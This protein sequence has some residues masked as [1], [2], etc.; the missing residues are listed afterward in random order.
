M[1]KPSGYAVLSTN[2]LASWHN[3]AALVIGWQ[4]LPC[5]VSD[6]AVVGNPL[7]MEETRYG[8]R[9]H[10]HLRI[11][12]GRALCALAAHHGLLLERALGSGYYPLG[13]RASRAMARLDPT[14]SVYLVHRYRPQAAGSRISP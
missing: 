10:R 12:T 11:F 7:A 1:L 2:N 13:I 4:P 5:H 9:I 3:V 8:E 14:H 6:E